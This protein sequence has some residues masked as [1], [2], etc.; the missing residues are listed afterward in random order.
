MRGS[1]AG[2]FGDHR[3]HRV[4]LRLVHD[5][6]RE[7]ERVAAA[8][9]MS[10]ISAAV[11][12]SAAGAARS[13]SGVSPN[14]GA[15]RLE[16]LARV[17]DDLHRDRP[18]LQ[19]DSPA[20]S[21]AAS[22]AQRTR[23]AYFSDDRLGRPSGPMWPAARLGT[24]LTVSAYRPASVRM[25]RL[26]PPMTSGG[27]PGVT[28][29]GSDRTPSTRYASPSKVALPV[30]HMARMISMHSA[31]RATRTAGRIHRD[32]GLLVVGRHPAGAEPELEAA[33]G[34][35]VER[36]RLLGQQRRG[37]GSRCRGRASRR[38]ASSWPPPPR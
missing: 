38:A 20:R 9:S 2:K 17:R 29:A 4:H 34:H 35:D 16:H 21:P 36:G 25:R 27:P 10:T 33:A 15:Q 7:A 14:D 8:R 26:P 13:C 5:D 30:S 3:R 1:G 31:S 11:P 24:T 6:V 12:I 22:R 19:L 18:A 32:A 37:G 28:G 23:S